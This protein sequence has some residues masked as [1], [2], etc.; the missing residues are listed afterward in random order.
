MKALGAEIIEF[1]QNN[2]VG[3]DWYYEDTDC[4]IQI[5]DEFGRIAILPSE[6]YDLGKFGVVC[7]QGAG[8][9]PN[10]YEDFTFERAF[11]QWKKSLLESGQRIFTVRVLAEKES[12]LRKFVGSLGGDCFPKGVE[13]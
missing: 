10:G 13:K 11:K 12:E 2:W 3:D 1:Y 4:E 9:P 8:I 7:W 5:E 6:K